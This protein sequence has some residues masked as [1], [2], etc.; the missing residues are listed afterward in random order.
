M[1]RCP[2]CSYRMEYEDDSF[3]DNE[4]NLKCRNCK[5]IIFSTKKA[6][7]FTNKKQEKPNTHTHMHATN[8]HFNHSSAYSIQGH[9][10]RYLGNIR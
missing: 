5:A 10:N 4:L 8:G 9:H 3:F 1:T 6:I 2:H 7:T